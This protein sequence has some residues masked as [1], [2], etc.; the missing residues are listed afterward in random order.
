MEK[1]LFRLSFILIFTFLFL[2]DS[3]SYVLA[4]EDTNYTPEEVKALKEVIIYLTEL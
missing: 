3:R 2:L 4:N 1:K